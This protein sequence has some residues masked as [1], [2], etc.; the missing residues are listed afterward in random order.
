MGHGDNHAERQLIFPFKPKS[1]VVQ[2]RKKV[3]LSSDSIGH[4]VVVVL[5]AIFSIL[6]KMVFFV[7][8]ERARPV[9]LFDDKHRVATDD[10]HVDFT[11]PPSWIWDS[12]GFVNM[13]AIC[14]SSGP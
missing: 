4:T 6:D 3:S 13:P 14:S 7:D 9:L 11:P 8:H 1:L 5:A 10:H 12:N 2:Y